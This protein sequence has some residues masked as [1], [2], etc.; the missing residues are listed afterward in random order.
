MMKSKLLLRFIIALVTVFAFHSRV[1][2]IMP[3]GG[4]PQKAKYVFLFIGDGMGLAQVNLTQGYLASLEG[5]IGFKQL[6]FTAFPQVGLMSN[7]ANDR[8][9]TCSAAAGTALA[10]GHKTNINRISYDP[11]GKEPFESVASKAK[12][13]GFKVGILTTVSIDHATPSVFYA[14]DTDRN[15]YFDIGTQLTRSDFDYF[16]GG[17]F[18]KMQ[19]TIGN[20]IINLAKLAGENGYNV[21]NTREAFDKLA[22]G[23]GKTLVLSSG[24]AGEESLPFYLDMDPDDITLADYTAKAINLLSGDKGFFMMVEGG[25][26]DWACHAN[27]A[28]TAIQ[29]VIEFDKAIDNAFSFYLKHKDET[30]IIVTAD[31]ETGALG[32]GNNKTGYDSYLDR[33]KYQKSSV[34]VLYKIFAQFR[35]NKTGDTIADFNKIMKVVENEIGIN[36][37]MNSTLLTEDELT[38]L[39]KTFV[40]SVY[41]PG[42]EKGSYGHR[43]PFIDAAIRLLA[44]KAG[45]SWGSNAH[46]FINV[47]VYAIGAGAE[48]FSGYIDNTDIPKRIAEL[49][50]IS[51]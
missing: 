48:R 31:H 37:R 20:K 8:L 16:A 40:E 29:E 27:D 44:E 13:N 15:M 47:P 3:S 7:Y 45:I 38:A 32:L 9:I 49:M 46:T 19:D 33:L 14:H 2:A 30:L 42:A 24:T 11:S 5:K 6:T 50:G 35:V 23:A 28:A 36:S 39:K 17:G 22:P 41:D 12:K 1:F 26:I 34:E 10:T 4:E 18:M 25:K 51:Q 21:V 43:E